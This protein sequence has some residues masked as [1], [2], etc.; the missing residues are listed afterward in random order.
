VVGLEFRAVA[1]IACDEGV[2]PLDSRIEDAADD[3]E[4]DEVYETERRLLFV[5]CTRARDR[6]M[7]S[8]VKPASEYLTD[9]LRG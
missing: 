8:G 2:L 5:A 3:A 1:V 4:M 6:L 9:L 7:V